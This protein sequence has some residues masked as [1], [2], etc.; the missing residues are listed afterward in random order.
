MFQDLLLYANELQVLETITCNLRMAEAFSA[1]SNSLFDVF[2]RF[3]PV[4]TDFGHPLWY[5]FEYGGIMVILNTNLN[6]H[7]L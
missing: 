5:I 4:N 2:F 3:V 7:F 6:R 1:K